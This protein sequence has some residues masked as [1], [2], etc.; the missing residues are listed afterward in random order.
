MGIRVDAVGRP[1][2]DVGHALATNEGLARRSDTSVGDS[3]DG[4]EIAET[5]RSPHL[6]RPV[7]GG[8]RF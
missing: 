6:L 5:V 7:S 2:L 8:S 4:E 3:C 1:R